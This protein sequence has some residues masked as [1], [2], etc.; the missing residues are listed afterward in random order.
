MYNIEKVR[1]IFDH[2]TEMRN[3]IYSTMSDSQ[4][5]LVVVRLREIAT[6]LDCLKPVDSDE[7]ELIRVELKSREVHYLDP[8]ASE[9]V[10]KEAIPAA[11]GPDYATRKELEAAVGTLNSTALV[12]RNAVLALTDRVELIEKALA[13]PVDQIEP[14]REWQRQH[15]YNQAYLAALPAVIKLG[16][17]PEDV[18]HLADR[19]ATQSLVVLK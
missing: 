16:H 6:E 2:I 5:R 13:R 19:I 8:K 18:A 14:D 9:R 12:D 1:E 15:L 17:S 3:T 7:G 10:A 4:R 11:P